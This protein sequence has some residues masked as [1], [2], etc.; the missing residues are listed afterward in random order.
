MK[1][2]AQGNVTG[3]LKIRD[4][5]T[6]EVLVD[7]PNAVHYGNMSWAVAHA[8]AGMDQGFI[9]YMLF[10]NGGT[11]VDSTGR[12]LYRQTNTSNV[13]DP[14]ALPYNPTF[15][16]ELEPAGPPTGNNIS[17]DPGL[18]NFADMVVTV[19]L[20]FGEPLD[21]DISDDITCKP[22]FVFDEIALYSTPIGLTDDRFTPFDTAVTSP[23]TP[24]SRFQGELDSSG[25]RMLTHVIFN[26]VQKSENRQ[27]EIEYTLRVSMGP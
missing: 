11:A 27:L 13:Q 24:V 22:E 12:V 2:T 26:P 23:E 21:Q 14:N 1:D 8:L 7:K 6:G 16:R 19:T 5:L 17:L 10:G 18:E 20:D 15:F 25:G 3:H 4:K 9:R